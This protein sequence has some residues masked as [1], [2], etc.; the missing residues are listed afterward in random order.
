MAR[1]IAQEQPRRRGGGAGRRIR[2][3]QPV[4]RADKGE[5]MRAAFCLLHASPQ[6][7]EPTTQVLIR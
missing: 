1:L 4:G 3:V 6:H 5:L 7:N 2:A